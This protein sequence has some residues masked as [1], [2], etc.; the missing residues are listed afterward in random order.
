VTR[1]AALA[2]LLASALAAH[3]EIVVRDDA[4]DTLRL[5]APARRIVALAPHV[6]ENLYAAGAG[7]RIVGAVDYSDYPPA[8]QAIARVGGYSRLDLERIVALKPD[9]VIAWQS[10]NEQG[11]V[12]R[13]KAVGL[14]VY[15][16][17]PGRFEDIAAEL[18]RFGAI[19]G[20]ETVAKA[21]AERF[22]A[23]LAGLRRTYGG[24]PRVRVFYEVWQDP[25]RTVG[26][27]QIISSV[28]TTCGG[29]NVFA[30]LKPMSPQVSHE[31]VLASDPE[32]FVAGGMGE[33]RRDWL[34]AWR[35]WPQLTAVK[36]D[37]LFF[38]PADLMQR[39]TLRLMDGAEMLCAQ[40]E[41]ARSRR[42]R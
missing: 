35:R 38:V 15:Q 8:A 31:A 39:H 1:R 37:N 7:D 29:E 19:A 24:R 12:G 20:T 41:T 42:P 2:L 5:P 6:V 10:G 17:Q 23:R 22:L 9:L 16:S 14:P 30:A 32:A 13:L 28:I 36:R 34:D 18:T 40:L 3:A 26:G 27:E 11:H 25:L 33:E 4:G 21:A